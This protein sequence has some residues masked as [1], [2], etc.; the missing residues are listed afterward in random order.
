MAL[1]LRVRVSGHDLGCPSSLSRLGFW[2]LSQPYTARRRRQRLA[3]TESSSAQGQKVSPFPQMEHAGTVP[4]LHST[5]LSLFTWLRKYLEVGGGG[6]AGKTERR[7]TSRDK[8]FP[9]PYQMRQGAEGTR[10]IRVDSRLYRVPFSWFYALLSR[11]CERLTLPSP[12]SCW[13]WYKATH[14]DTDTDSHARTNTHTTSPYGAHAS[15][16]F[17]ATGFRFGKT[18]VV[19]EFVSEE[20]KP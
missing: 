18:P 7:L 15:H 3:R 6:G 16:L 4:P 14:T 19:G 10:G 17:L 20:P 1:A 5:P 11:H 9:N 8:S 13:L 2:Q 12:S